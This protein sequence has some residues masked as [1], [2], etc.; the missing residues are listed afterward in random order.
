MRVLHAAFLAV[1]LPALAWMPAAGAQAQRAALAQSERNAVEL[2]QGMTLEEVQKLLGKP[3]RTALKSANGAV[4]DPS[5]GTL[6]W[7]YAW[8]RERI[9]NVAFAAKTPHEWY[10][11]S[12]DWATY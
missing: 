10:V 4:A 9:L 2:K 8:S 11:N 3:T 7:T 5:Q 12:W 6:Q 1:L